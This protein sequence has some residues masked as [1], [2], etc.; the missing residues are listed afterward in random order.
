MISNR[1]RCNILN[2]CLQMAENGRGLF[3]LTVPTGGGKTLSSLAFALEHAKHNEQRRVIYV[4]PYTS[5]IEQTAEEFRTVLG[6]RNV[7]EHQHNFQYDYGDDRIDRAASPPKIGTNP[8]SSPPTSSFLNPSSQ[9]NPP[10]A[11]SSTISRAVS[12]SSTRRRCCRGNT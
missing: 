2:R 8:L 7:L 5:I 4:I 1:M 6:D 12:S 11:A 3:T 10:A 9:T